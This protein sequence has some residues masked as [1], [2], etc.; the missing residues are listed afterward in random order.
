[1]SN[2]HKCRVLEGYYVYDLDQKLE[3]GKVDYDSRAHTIAS[4][5]ASNVIIVPIQPYN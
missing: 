2:K 3:K 5:H 1:M 4:K